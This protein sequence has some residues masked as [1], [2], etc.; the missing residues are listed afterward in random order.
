MIML[1]NLPSSNTIQP[2]RVQ[3]DDVASAKVTSA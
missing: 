2:V 1:H 3:A